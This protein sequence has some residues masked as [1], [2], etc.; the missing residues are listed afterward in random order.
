MPSDFGEQ[1]HNDIML[2]LH[3]AEHLRISTLHFGTSWI[4]SFHANE[5]AKASL[6][7][8]QFAPLTL[9]HLIPSSEGT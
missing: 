9:H 6:A 3:G 8:G 1:D 7:L 5:L 4:E 2:Q